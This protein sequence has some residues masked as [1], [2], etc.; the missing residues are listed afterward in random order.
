MSD[1]YG[2]TLLIVSVLIITIVIVYLLDR[3]HRRRIRRIFK[4]F[5]ERE[6]GRLN[7]ENRSVPRV[8]IPESL[9]VR[10]VIHDERWPRRAGRVVDLSLSGLAVEPNFPLKKL[11]LDVEL[12]CFDVE[13]PINRFTLEKVRAVRVEHQLGRRVLAFKILSV[14]ERDF[15][16]MKR[17]IVYMDAFSK[18]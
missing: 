7:R 5:S 8:S 4:T 2:P 10:F 11:P 15:S 14:S 9:E 1:R 17:F 3:W 18:S 16:E 12:S 6:A 13:T